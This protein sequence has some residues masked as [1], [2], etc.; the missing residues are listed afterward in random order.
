MQTTRIPGRERSIGELFGELAS[1]TGTL[2]RQ[3]VKLATTEMS[4]KAAYAGKRAGLIAAGGV[5]A[6]VSV[7]VLT[8][9]IVLLLGLVMPYW[10]SALIVAALVGVAAYV[11]IKAGIRALKAFDLKPSETIAS[12]KD[13]KSWVQKQLH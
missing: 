11:V 4:Q 13:N 8:A 10:A 6:L 9:G 12:L 3:E 1:E 2:V 7:L 5:L